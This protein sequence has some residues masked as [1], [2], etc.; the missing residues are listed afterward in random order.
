MIVV[1]A[2]RH[3]FA[4]GSRIPYRFCVDDPIAMA[5]LEFH[6]DSCYDAYYILSLEFRLLALVHIA[7]MC[8]IPNDLPL[9]KHV[10]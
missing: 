1:G 5:S 2:V 8:R 9:H 10:C 3:L 7:N 6:I 4:C